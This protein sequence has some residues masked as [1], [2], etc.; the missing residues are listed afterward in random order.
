MLFVYNNTSVLSSCSFLLLSCKFQTE[1]S[2][3]EDLREVN[4]RLLLQVCCRIQSEYSFR[5]A[6]GGVKQHSNELM[7]TT[8]D[9]YVCYALRQQ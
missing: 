5:C 2:L 1:K 9:E 3:I 7:V 4:K 6:V 8:S